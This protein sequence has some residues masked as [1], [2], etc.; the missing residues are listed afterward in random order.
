MRKIDGERTTDRWG[1]VRERTKR[2]TELD[3]ERQ[4]RDGEMKRVGKGQNG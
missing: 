2:E 3:V 1:K 4:H